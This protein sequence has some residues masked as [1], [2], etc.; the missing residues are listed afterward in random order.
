MGKHIN[1][2]GYTLW[3]SD[4]EKQLPGKTVSSRQRFYSPSVLATYSIISNFSVGIFLYSINLS[5]RGYLWRGR[6]LAILSMLFLGFLIFQGFFVASTYRL[7]LL[8]VLVAAM[9]YGSEKP[10]FD[11]AI[12]NGSKPA[13]W[14]LPLI[15]IAVIVTI[16]GFSVWMLGQ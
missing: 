5:R 9:L 11:R 13:R 7:G 15:L 6:V 14:W 12:R 1:F 16:Y 8:N 10:H 2:L 3:V 4:G